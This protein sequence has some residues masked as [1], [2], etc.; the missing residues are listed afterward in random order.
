LAVHPE[1]R[2]AACERPAL[3]IIG[4]AVGRKDESPVIGI[5]AAE[6]GFCITAF[7]IKKL[8]DQE[9]AARGLADV[10]GPLEQALWSAVGTFSPIRSDDDIDVVEIG[11]AFRTIPFPYVGS[12]HGKLSS[13]NTQKWFDV[14]RPG[15]GISNPHSYPA[16][17]SAG[18]LGFFVEDGT[19]HTSSPIIM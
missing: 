3:G 1:T 9:L 4:L 2:T 7:V 5:K 6:E 19:A 11:D 16:G 8:S 10:R 15:I 18:T 12:E 14:L 13:L 17:L